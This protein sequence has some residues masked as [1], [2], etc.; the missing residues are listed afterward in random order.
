MPF[1]IKA[2]LEKVESYLRADGKIPVASIGEPKSITPGVQVVGAVY[3]NRV[4]VTRVMVGGNTEELHVVTIR[5]Y[6]DML[7]EPVKTVEVALAAMVQRILSD[8]VGDF[9]LG[10]SVRNVDV[11]GS[12]GS[13]VATDWGYV[14][15]G[16]KM[17]RIADITLP[18]I[19][20]G[21]A[22]AAP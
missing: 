3:M 20:D 5:L 6:R 14:D 7:A 2:T 13:P 21:S 22:T 8:V 4:A 15:V 18:L 19:V 9:D 10:A 11:G 12:N 1:D 16:G 17:Y